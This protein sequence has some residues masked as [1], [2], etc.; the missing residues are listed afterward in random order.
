MDQLKQQKRSAKDSFRFF[1]LRGAGAILIGIHTAL[2]LYGFF[3]LL[4]EAIRLLTF[5]ED[6]FIYTFQ[7]QE[8]WLYNL[9]FGYIASIFAMAVAFK[10]RIETTPRQ[11]RQAGY[12]RDAILNDLTGLNLFFLFLATQVSFALGIV[13]ASQGYFAFSFYPHYIYI[14]FFIVIVLYLQ[15]WKT[16]RMVLGRKSLLRMGIC[17][18][19]VSVMAFL[20]SF[21]QVINYKEI[22]RIILSK[23]APTKYQMQYPESTFHTLREY[24]PFRLN[25]YLAL[26]DNQKEVVVVMDGEVVD[27]LQLNAK[28]NE[29]KNWYPERFHVLLMA[30]L[31]IDKRIPVKYVE[32]LKEQLR[33]CNIYRIAYVLLKNEDFPNNYYETCL[34]PS[35]IP[36]QKITEENLPGSDNAVY[37]QFLPGN[38]LSINYECFDLIKGKQQLSS[39]MLQHSKKTVVIE[40]TT[41]ESYDT[42][43]RKFLFAEEI[44]R[45]NL[46]TIAMQEF[47]E[48]F[49]DLIN[50]EAEYVLRKGNFS[51]W[52]WTKSSE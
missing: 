40:C 9:F 47:Q 46:K 42:Y 4:R 14:L 3:Y 33:E 48:T 12:F 30:H 8:V 28:I 37:I 27:S 29:I 10:F 36:D 6:H 16:I 26:D 39:F 2:A 52:T 18:L 7:D 17:F 1:S 13:L 43:L 24:F 45:N 23:H 49:D 38:K 44:R 41:E 5:H 31:H 15:C 25:I 51:I 35:R 50:D 21:I 20:L 19:I 22:N 11:M 34:I 32:R